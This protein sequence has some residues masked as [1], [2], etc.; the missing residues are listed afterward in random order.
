M[1]INNTIR[2][3]CYLQ[4]QKYIDYEKEWMPE[5]II[6]YPFMHKRISFEHEKEVRAMIWRAPTKDE[7]IDFSITTI[8][9]G[10]FASIDLNVLINAIYVSPT[11]PNWFYEL[12]CAIVGKF[13]IDKPIKQSSLANNSPIF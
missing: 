5:G 2:I 8:D 1:L 7:E 13:G 3:R 6:F 9:D 11:S 12:V 10:I 4:Y